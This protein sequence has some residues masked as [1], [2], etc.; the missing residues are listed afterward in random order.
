MPYPTYNSKSVNLAAEGKASGIKKEKKKPSFLN[1]KVL[2]NDG[3]ARQF[4]VKSKTKMN[5]VMVA[6]CDAERLDRWS[7][8]FVYEGHRIGDH[9]TAEGLGMTDGDTVEAFLMQTGGRI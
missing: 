8:R 9:N 4:K 7:V 2:N 5:K 6:Y 1:I 3:K